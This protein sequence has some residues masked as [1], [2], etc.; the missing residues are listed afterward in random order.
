MG[1][2]DEKDWL[3]YYQDAKR[4]SYKAAN[5][6]GKLLQAS[7]TALVTAYL[8]IFGA[9]K[10]LDRLPTAEPQA[11]AWIRVLYQVRQQLSA[12][13]QELRLLAVPGSSVALIL[14][15]AHLP[16]AASIITASRR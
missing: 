6:T 12:H 15:Q 16:Y 8:A 2:Q 14:D 13:R 7:A 11:S 5:D 9:L 10:I 1:S 3:K 4:E